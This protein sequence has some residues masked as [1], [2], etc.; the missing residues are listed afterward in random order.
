MNKPRTLSTCTDAE[1]TAMAAEV[2]GW[3]LKDGAWID[4]GGYIQ[5]SSFAGHSEE[6]NPLEDANDAI[7]LTEHFAGT[8][9]VIGVEF[10]EGIWRAT[11][12]A[13]IEEGEIIW[14]DDKSAP[15]AL[16][17]AVLLAAGKVVEWMEIDAL[18]SIE[19]MHL[20]RIA[21]LEAYLKAAQAD[22]EKWKRVADQAIECGCLYHV[23]RISK[24]CAIEGETPTD[25]VIELTGYL[26]S[27][28]KNDA[29]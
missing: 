13:G 4:D 8:D 25:N 1:L 2:R 5:A 15:R 21:T 17:I 3:T 26:E 7:E 9:W 22:A 24:I 10:S 6:W 18:A 23:E 12:V 27:K 11:E 16:T 29:N 20:G 19:S 28:E 14:H